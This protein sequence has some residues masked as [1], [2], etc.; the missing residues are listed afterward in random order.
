MPG[1]LAYSAEMLDT[2]V[3]LAN[4]F[5]GLI[6]SPKLE[7]QKDFLIANGPLFSVAIGLALRDFI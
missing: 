4:P 7:N 1:L 6:L 3:E 5:E 2:E